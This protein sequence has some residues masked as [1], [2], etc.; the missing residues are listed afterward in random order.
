MDNVKCKVIILTGQP[1]EREDLGRFVIDFDSLNINKESLSVDFNHNDELPLGVISNIRFE[2]GVGLV[3]DAVLSSPNESDKA[4]EIVNRISQ[5]Y[6]FECSPTLDLTDPEYLPQGQKAI[7]NGMEIEG[8]CNIYRNADLRGVAVCLFGTDS[9]TS[10][11]TL[12]KQLTNLKLTGVKQTMKK[13]ELK[14]TDAL[15]QLADEVKEESETETAETKPEYLQTLEA[16]IES[17]GLS[18]GVGYFRQGLTIE[19]AEKL[20]YEELKKLRSKLAEKDDEEAGEGEGGDGGT[21]DGTADEGTDEEEEKKEDLKAELTELKAE[22]TKLRAAFGS[23]G[24]DTPVSATKKQEP[25]N[26]SPIQKMAEKI[27][28]TGIKRA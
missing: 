1:I 5:N 12:K 20:D 6:P 24:E 22:L 10:L 8:E 11:M 28:R 9:G 17:F 15:V 19:E 16:M 2:P 7:V 23:R 27:K 18:A 4:Y 21:D 25:D 26:L 14:D 3:G 13:E